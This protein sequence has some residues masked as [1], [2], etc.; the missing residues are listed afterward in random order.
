[1]TVM[2]GQLDIL[3]VLA[4]EEARERFESGTLSGFTTSDEF[5][6]WELHD[7]FVAWKSVHGNLGSYQRSHMWHLWNLGAGWTGAHQPVQVS[8]DLRNPPPPM[9]GEPFQGPGCLLYRLYCTEC[10][11]W[12]PITDSSNAA[13]RAYLDHCW[14]GWRALPA[15][16]HGKKDRMGAPHKSEIPQDYPEE[17]MVPGA[18]SINYVPDR[19]SST[20]YSRPSFVPGYSAFGGIGI[21]IHHAHEYPELTG[22]TA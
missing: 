2:D 16:P 9:R 17:W 12:T 10:E 15:I 18:P 6:P 5:D 11:W 19:F 22:V 7:A 8:C 20:S 14:P 21:S 13:S 4:E 1:M 3:A